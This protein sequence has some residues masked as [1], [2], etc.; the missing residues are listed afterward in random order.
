MSIIHKLSIPKFRPFHCSLSFSRSPVLMSIIHKLS[1]PNRTTVSPLFAM[2]PE[3]MEE[4]EPN[5]MSAF[6]MS[7]A[8]DH[9]MALKSSE[10]YMDGYQEKL[11]K[12]KV[13][14]WNARDS[15]ECLIMIDGLQRLAID[16]HFEEEIEAILGRINRSIAESD[17]VYDDN[18]LY[19]VS[20]R[21]RLLRQNG[22]HPS[23]DVFNKFKDEKETFKLSLREDHRGIME[24]FEASELRIEGEIILDEAS[25]FASKHLNDVLKHVGEDEARVIRDTLNHPFN[26]SLAR[27]K[28][29]PYIK[30]FE[31]DYGT[32]DILQELVK[33]DF[34]IVQTLHQKELL[35][36]SM[37]WKDLGLTRELKF[38]RNQPVKWYLWSI[39][40]LSDP[41]YSKERIELTKPISLIYIMDDIFD[42]Q[43]TFDELVL[44]TEAINMWDLSAMEKLPHYM[45]VFYKVIYDITDD[46]S[47][48]VFEEHGC[49]PSN[50]LRKAWGKLCDAFLMEAKWFASGKVPEAEEYLKNG[51]ISTGVH[52][53][54]QDGHDGSYINCYLKENRSSTVESARKHVFC[55][56]SD[57]WKRLNKECLSSTPFSSSFVKASLNA[58]RMVSLMYSYDD[59][60]Q[61]PNLE[62]HIKSLLYENITL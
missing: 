11:K 43:G 57:A 13:A 22:Y 17:G 24:L 41:R 34:N 4:Q 51:T 55:M 9:G 29:K 16:Y 37:W 6:F 47:S 10:D 48:K 54:K 59:N 56:I 36:V 39:A 38:A 7:V 32:N 28:A 50:S 2:A 1:I 19:Y 3:T 44:F 26:K 20:L 25:V 31:R 27:F 5:N 61:L 33:V 42:V 18:D 53:E 30:N 62:E 46:I 14:L 23:A 49:N 40:A 45:K 60:H 58:A 15:S 35:E 8:H 12:L 52:D 21:F